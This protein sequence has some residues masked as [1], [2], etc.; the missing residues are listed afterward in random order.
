MPLFGKLRRSTHDKR[1]RIARFGSLSGA[2]PHSCHK[3]GAF[4]PMLKELESRDAG[5]GLLS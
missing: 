4:R 1:G 3:A 2:V 5:V